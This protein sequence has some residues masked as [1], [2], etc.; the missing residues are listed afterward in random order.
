MGGGIFFTAAAPR[1]LARES[2]RANKQ[3]Q[4]FFIYSSFFLEKV[5]LLLPRYQT[6]FPVLWCEGL[7]HLEHNPSSI[8]QT[9]RWVRFP[10]TLSTTLGPPP[11][12]AA[13]CAFSKHALM[14]YPSSAL[15]HIIIYIVCIFTLTGILVDCNLVSIHLA[16]HHDRLK[17]WQC[18]MFLV[19]IGR[20]I[21]EK[22]LL[23][24][25]WT[26]C[27]DTKGQNVCPGQFGIAGGGHAGYEKGKPKIRESLS[28]VGARSRA[29]SSNQGEFDIFLYLQPSI[30]CID[31]I[32]IPW[33]YP[34]KYGWFSLI[35]SFPWN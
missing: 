9:S 30:Q 35:P 1:T 8:K 34:S 13:H 21:T 14:R 19:W 20:R 4:S 11:P 3:N 24:V 22:V 23:R 15:C 12:R 29:F 33:Y 2:S 32:Y 17:G 25:D 31:A 10:L 18:G 5:R 28:L 27:L 6:S 26:F 16:P 7:D